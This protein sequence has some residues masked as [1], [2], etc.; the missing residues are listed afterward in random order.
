M[1]FIIKSP[2]SSRP[3]SIIGSIVLAALLVGAVLVFWPVG[4]GT[5]ESVEFVIENGQT[6]VTAANLLAEQNLI[7]NRTLFV[8]YAI[9]LGKEKKFKA[10]RYLIPLPVSTWGLVRT[11][12][13]GEAEP[14]NIRV[15]IPEGTNIADV[16]KIFAEATLTMPGDLL[17]YN[18]K[19]GSVL[20]QEGYLFPDTYFFK[21]PEAGQMGS[22][23][24]IV[25][26]MKENF[27]EKTKDIFAGRFMGKG[28]IGRGYRA[29][30]I[31][32]ILEKE[33]KTEEDMK[34]VAG[35]IEKRLELGMPLQ[36]DATVAYGVCLNDFF[37]GKYCDVS[38]AN[39][40]DNIPIDSE[41]NTY[42][43][44]GLPLGPISNPGLKAIN[45]ALNPV[46]SDY[47]F[48]L[49][50]RDGTTIFSKTAAEHEHARQKYLTK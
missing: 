14:D 42:S 33:V 32:S 30:I 40:V 12:S 39:L 10:G 34:L 48:Y 47:L 9:F 18:L 8:G 4:S 43:R 1:A 50:A 19:H 35:I 27:N 5:G 44:K 13:R 22:V 46:S 37:V 23:E 29:I 31:A 24:E 2:T 17:S 45:A 25:A 41:Y 15:T 7:L 20:A 38:Q 49:S 11:F 36:I 26:K 3:Y 16:D 6:L 28:G 21:R